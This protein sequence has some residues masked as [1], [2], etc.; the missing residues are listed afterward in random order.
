VYNVFKAG[1]KKNFSLLGLFLTFNFFWQGTHPVATMP[2]SDQLSETDGYLH[3][4]GAASQVPSGVHTILQCW[5]QSGSKD[6]MIK[7][8]VVFYI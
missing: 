8:F 3:R 4:D 2:E 6:L 5:F 1:N 7:K